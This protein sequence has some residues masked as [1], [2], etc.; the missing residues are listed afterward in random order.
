VNENFIHVGRVNENFIHVGRVN[1]NFIHV[2]RVN[3]TRGNFGG[4]K[5][6]RGG[7]AKLDL[8]DFKSFLSSISD[9][10]SAK[11]LFASLA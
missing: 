7:R 3:D 2:G 6:R 8:F 9:K 5:E 10:I 4:A 1:E 11:I